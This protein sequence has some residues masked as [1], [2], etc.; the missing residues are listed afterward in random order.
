MKVI[1]DR[2][3]ESNARAYALFRAVRCFEPSGSNDCGNQNIPSSTRKEW[4]RMLHKE[5]PD[6]VWAKSSKYYW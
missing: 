3:A 1:A 6:S 4:F 5:Y 2:Q